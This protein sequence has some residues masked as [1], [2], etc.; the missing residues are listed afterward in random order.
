MF[1]EYGKHGAEGLSHNPFKNL[2]VPRP[3]GWISTLSPDGVANLAPYSFFNGVAD[4]PPIV[5]FATN[6]RS[7]AAGLKDS[8]GNAEA[9]G[10]F[11]VNLA[12]WELRHQMSASS[13]PFP[14][15]V[16]EFAA[17]GLTPAPSRLVNPPRVAESPV[18]LE[19]RYLRTVELPSDDPESGNFV[20]FGQV[21]AIH[22]DDSLVTEAG[23]VDI[24]SVKPIARLGYMDYVAVE[25]VFEIIRPTSVKP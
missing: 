4:A 11:V 7:R 23:R 17:V 9:T 3:I 13:A 12:T 14:P 18:Q 22:I 15:E 6:G 2:V 19:C 25:S 16:D 20:V 1:F 21:L 8:Q 24:A 5:F 10:E